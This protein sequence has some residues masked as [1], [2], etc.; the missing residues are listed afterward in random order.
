VINT[1]DGN[2]TPSG[3][4]IVYAATTA[5]SGLYRFCGVLLGIYQL[6]VVAPPTGVPYAS[7]GYWLEAVDLN[8]ATTM[9]EPVN[10]MS[11][12]SDGMC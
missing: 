5:S 6:K 3:D 1:P 2:T 9:L 4:D 7:A 8:G 12:M 11:S 10:V